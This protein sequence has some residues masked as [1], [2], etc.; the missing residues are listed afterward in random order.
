MEQNKAVCRN[1]DCQYEQPFSDASFCEKCGTRLKNI[2]FAKVLNEKGFEQVCRTLNSDNAH[3]C[4]LC[5][6]DLSANFPKGYF[7]KAAQS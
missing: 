7:K 6:N 1:P 5:G 3:F 2:C 4:R